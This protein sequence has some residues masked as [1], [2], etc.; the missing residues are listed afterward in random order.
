M[1]ETEDWTMRKTLKNGYEIVRSVPVSRE[2]WMWKIIRSGDKW[3]FQKVGLVLQQ[4][5][6]WFQNVS[7]HCTWNHLAC[8]FVCIWTQ[9]E[10]LRMDEPMGNRCNYGIHGSSLSLAKSGLCYPAPKDEINEC[11]QPLQQII[12]PDRDRGWRGC[13]Y[14]A[15]LF[16]QLD[17]PWQGGAAHGDQV[18]LRWTWMNFQWWRVLCYGMSFLDL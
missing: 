1:R 14:R 16:Q 9:L 18:C 7:V 5:R 15:Q 8:V 17:L 12:A 4:G 13:R 6:S 11:N 2:M 3:G 10:T